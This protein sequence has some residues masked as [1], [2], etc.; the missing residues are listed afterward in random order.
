MTSNAPPRSEDDTEISV[1][2]KT[3][4]VTDQRLE[5]LTAGEVDTVTDRDGRSYM[6]RRAQNEL[7]YHEAARQAAILNALPAHIVLL[8]TNGVIVS[9]NDAWRQLAEANVLMDAA[10][11]IGV[12]YLAVCDGASGPDAPTAHALAAGIRSVLIGRN[13]RFSVE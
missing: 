6:L 12:D 2:I 7:R 5:E 4:R 3:L 1:L 13:K 11:G 9:V 8:D 10:H